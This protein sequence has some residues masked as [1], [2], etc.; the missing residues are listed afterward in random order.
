MGFVVAARTGVFLPDN[1]PR[2]S[3]VAD[4]NHPVPEKQEISCI[5]FINDLL[6]TGAQND[7]Y[8]ETIDS[9]LHVG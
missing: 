7:Q 8:V 5:L 2:V 6:I 3:I 1:L 4:I 9:I